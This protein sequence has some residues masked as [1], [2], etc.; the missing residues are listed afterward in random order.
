MEPEHLD[1]RRN[2]RSRP[3]ASIADP[4]AESER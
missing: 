2:A 3:R 1:G 4:F